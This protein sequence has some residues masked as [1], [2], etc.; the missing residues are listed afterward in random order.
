MSFSAYYSSAFSLPVNTRL[1]FIVLAHF[2]CP[3]TLLASLTHL[4]II[5]MLLFLD[6]ALDHHKRPSD[7][8]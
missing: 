7:L 2:A 4:I 6:T 5:K 3:Q 1:G 8:L